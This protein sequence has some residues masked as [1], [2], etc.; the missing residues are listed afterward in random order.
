MSGIKK[1][2]PSKIAKDSA[3]LTKAGRTD[4]ITVHLPLPIG[5]GQIGPKAVMQKLSVR[6]QS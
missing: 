5:V 6:L 1:L 3:T 2:I 4:V